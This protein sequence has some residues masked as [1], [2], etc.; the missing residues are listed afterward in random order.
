MG[1]AV[2]T[3]MNDAANLARCA[4]SR[5]F[6]YGVCFA[7]LHLQ[8]QVTY[9]NALCS[10]SESCRQAGFSSDANDWLGLCVGIGSAFVS[11]VLVLC[12]VYSIT[13]YLWNVWRIF[14]RYQAA[15][16]SRHA[17]LV[18]FK[19]MQD[20][21]YWATCRL[22]CF[23]VPAC[24]MFVWNFIWLLAKWIMETTCAKAA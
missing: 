18:P 20:E 12:K 6:I 21:I 4:F 17:V 11:M 24:L 14:R 2:R 8:F 1:A 16:I 10:A 7:G 9:A 3:L 15:L 23:L 5:I 19:T 13:K 22:Y